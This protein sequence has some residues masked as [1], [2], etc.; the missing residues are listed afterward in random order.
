[1]PV[2]SERLKLLAE[3]FAPDELEWRVGRMGVGAR[4]PW[5]HVLAYQT[6]RAVMDRFDHVC[7][8]ENWSNE[9]RAGP[10]GG[11]ICRISVNVAGTGWISKEDGAENTEIEAV[12]GGLSGSMKRA[13]VQ[14]GCGR[15]LYGLSEP[16]GIVHEF[17]SH[18]AG[19]GPQRFRWNPPPLPDWA[20]PAGAQRHGELLAF[21]RDR[22]RMSRARVRLGDVWTRVSEFVEA[23]GELL[24]KD[25]FLCRQLASAIDE[26][27]LPRVT[28]ISGRTGEELAA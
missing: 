4:G 22:A 8:P 2:E 13:A 18:A 9:F 1:M 20:L 26:D 3:P 25:F 7:G 28:E 27:R 23:H 12:K 21:I 11:V 10:G 24:R 5:V 6:C 19:K 15:Y 16:F 17:G 14:W